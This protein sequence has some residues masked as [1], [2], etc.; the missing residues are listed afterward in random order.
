MKRTDF[1][2]L[3]LGVALTPLVKVLPADAQPLDV[4]ADEPLPA[5]PVML[6]ALSAC[7]GIGPYYYWS[8]D[9]D[10][11]TTGTRFTV[12]GFSSSAAA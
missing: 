2:K 6:D 8:E 11:F 7:T 10:M 5:K 9:G 12:P 1:L 3:G 4:I